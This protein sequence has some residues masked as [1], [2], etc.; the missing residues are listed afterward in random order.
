M[1]NIY[2]DI[3]TTATLPGAGIWDIGA[4]AAKNGRPFGH[5]STQVRVPGTAIRDQSTLKW[6]HADQA[7]GRRYIK[8]QVNGKSEAQ[9]LTELTKWLREMGVEAHERKDVTMLSWGTFD[10]PLLKAAYERQFDRHERPTSLNFETP[11]HYGAE[12]DLRSVAKFLRYDERPDTSAHEAYEDAYAL[13]VF[14]NRLCLYIDIIS[15][16]DL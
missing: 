13:M 14:H 2:L 8:T 5:F 1:I 7:R 10:F 4:V 3:E 16:K 12:C 6:I 15:P 11:W 9:A